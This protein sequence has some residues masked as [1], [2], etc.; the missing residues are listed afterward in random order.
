MRRCKHKERDR[1]KETRTEETK[2]EKVKEL[3]T[4]YGVKITP[5]PH[6]RKEHCEELLAVDWRMY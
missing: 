4:S 2:N 6:Q 3:K 5:P 1:G